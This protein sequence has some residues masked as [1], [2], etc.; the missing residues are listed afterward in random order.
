MI[1]LQNDLIR[2][3][4][5][6]LELAKLEIKK[7]VFNKIRGV[8]AC[9]SE[10]DETAYITFYYNGEVKE[11][12]IEAAS[13]ICAYVISHLIKGSLNEQYKRLDYPTSL[14]DNDFWVYRRE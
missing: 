7:E 1:N 12:D 9:W 2:F 8:T 10:L 4:V 5:Y 3:T 14:P 13:E 6:E 11:N